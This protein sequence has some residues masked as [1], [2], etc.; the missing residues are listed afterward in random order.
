MHKRTAAGFAIVLL[1]LAADLTPPVRAGAAADGPATV[2]EIEA[3]MRKARVVR[4]RGLN[5]GVTR[6]V[7]LTLT[8]GATTHDAVFQGIDEKRN[9]FVPTRGRAEMNFVDSWRYNVAA[10]RIS[11]LLG[12]DGMMPVTIE[13]TYRGRRGAL[14]WWLESIMDERERREKDIKPPNPLAWNQ[15]IYRMRIFTAL[16]HDTDRNL[17][18]M[19]ISPDW[20]MLMVDFT[21]AFRLH[22]EINSAEIHQ[23]DRRLFERL[24]ALAPAAVRD[25]VGDYLTPSEVSAV[26]KR[27]DML[28]DHVRGLIAARG[29]EKVLY[30]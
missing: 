29:E 27:R 21:R 24:E 7:R 13:Y 1:W 23:C 15:D 16:V 9:V 12:L 25:A 5:T 17:G 20:R 10:W 3:F 30:E 8:D 11:R 2:E 22:A 28:V 18:N 4:S 6:P 14:S 19:L 26:M